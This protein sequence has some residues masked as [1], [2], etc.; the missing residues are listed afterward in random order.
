MAGAIRDKVFYLYT[1][2]RLGC[3]TFMSKC[4]YFQNLIPEFEQEQLSL[5]SREQFI[6]HIENCKDCK[7]E[8]EI[9]YLIEYG[10]N[11]TTIHSNNMKYKPYIDVLDFKAVVEKKLSDAKQDIKDIKSM[12][13]FMNLC[14]FSVEAVM[15]LTVIIIIIILFF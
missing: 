4:K 6:K 7:E 5:K 9:Y 14:L 10:L 11:D 12:N 8:F 3:L 13:K 2:L 15:I 1:G